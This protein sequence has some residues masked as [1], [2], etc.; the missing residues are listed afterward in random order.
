LGGCHPT[1]TGK[2]AEKPE[3]S[4]PTVMGADVRIDRSCR[5]Q[6]VIALSCR[7]R[8]GKRALTKPAE[9]TGG[10]LDISDW[11]N[12]PVGRGNT[13]GAATSTDR[14]GGVTDSSPGRRATPQTVGRRRSG[15]EWC[16]S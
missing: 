14:D 4:L 1:G 5:C 10:K 8:L 12:S 6:L 15:V 7:T 11:S 9:S 3:S 2:F 16:G 13:R